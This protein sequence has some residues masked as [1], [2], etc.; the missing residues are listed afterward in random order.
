MM[1]VNIVKRAKE[2]ISNGF[3]VT[4]TSNAFDFFLTTEMKMEA[5]P[6]FEKF[7]LLD[8][9]DV[10][11]TIK[12]WMHHPDMILSTL[13]RLLIERRLL[14]VK[15]RA[16][17]FDEEWVSEMRNIICKKLNI[18]ERE[19]RYFIFTGE[20]EN[21]TYDPSEER[22]NILFKDGSVKDISEV[23]NALIHQTLSTPVKKFYICFFNA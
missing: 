7:C 9:Y 23:D 14:K 11:A 13:C 21:T 2:L 4:S 20:A 18:T 8:D 19:S 10:M 16:E 15:L 17:P 12:N 6:P 3:L 5:G 1:L 22:I